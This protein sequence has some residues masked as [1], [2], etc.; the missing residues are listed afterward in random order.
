MIDIISLDFKKKYLK[1]N[2]YYI[3]YND[4][5]IIFTYLFFKDNL[6]LLQIN[7]IDLMVVSGKTSIR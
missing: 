3:Y 7:Y 4:H 6:E 2:K 1:L 5:K